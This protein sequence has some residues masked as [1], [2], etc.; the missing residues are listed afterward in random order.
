MGLDSIWMMPIVDGEEKELPY[1]EPE[2]TLI[3]GLLFDNPRSFRGKVYNPLIEFI[4]G[5]S[6]YAK[7]IDNKGV[8]EIA[9]FLETYNPEEH[10]GV[11]DELLGISG[12]ASIN[13][14]H[15]NDLKRAFRTFGDAGAVL[16]GWW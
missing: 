7:E 12:N 14:H 16:T 6:L 2:L 10:L 15:Y 13:L 8:K 5:V 11:L 4:T 3:V 1:F 9:E